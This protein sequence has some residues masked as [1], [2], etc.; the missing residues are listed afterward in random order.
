MSDLK[1]RDPR[2]YHLQRAA[3]HLDC[4]VQCARTL[5]EGAE[6]DAMERRLDELA[7]E[8]AGSRG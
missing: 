8:D 5:E 6:L 3:T 4:A 7:K 2:R 1:D